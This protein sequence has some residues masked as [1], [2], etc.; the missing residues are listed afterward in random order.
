MAVNMKANDCCFI[1][2]VFYKK[3]Y[4]YAGIFTYL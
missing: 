2:V 1:F 3:Y 4:N